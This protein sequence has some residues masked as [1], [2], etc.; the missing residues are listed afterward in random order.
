MRL[1]LSVL[2]LL[3]CL[4]ILEFSAR[5]PIRALGWSSRD[6][7]D[8]ISPYVQTRAW[9]SGRDP[10]APSTL[11]ELWPASPRPPFLLKESADGTLPAKRGLPSPYVAI[12]FPLLLPFAELPWRIAIC[13]WVVVCV[14]AVF[15]VAWALIEFAGVRRST[16]LALLILVS[17]LLLAPVQTAVAASNIVNPVFALGMVAALCQTQNR[18][19]WAGVLLTIAVG[20]KATVA[21]PFVIYALANRNRSKVIPAAIATGILLLSVTIIPQHGRTLWW[22]SFLANNQSMF[23]PGAIDDFS[24]ANPLHFQLVNLQA[25]LFPILQNRALTQFA[26]ALVFVI[27]LAFWFRAMRRDGQV[28]LLDLAILASAA[29]LPVYHRFTDA[30]LLLVPVA[31]ALREMQSERKGFAAGCLLL[32][33]PFLIPGAAVLHEFSGRSEILQNLSRTRLWHLFI[34]PHQTWLILILC[35]LLLTARSLP[36]GYKTSS[37]GT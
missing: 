12:A 33:S 5:G 26:A 35:I 16:T 19:G 23:A 11:A 22:K 34:L 36:R 27:L 25:A 6:F 13:V 31:W 14:L 24:T 32:A 2:C 30:G 17:V 7:N 8:F 21:L 9:F 15:T 37:A 10:Y 29:L 3:A 1:R 20:L 4:A 28:G 18:N